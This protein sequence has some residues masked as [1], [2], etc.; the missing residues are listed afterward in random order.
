MALQSK[1]FRGDPKLEAAAVS[2]PAHI[3]QGARGEHVRKIQQALI[4]LDGADIKADGDYGPATAKAVLAY[5]T[6]R[7]II[8][9]AYQTQADDIVGKMTMA[10]LDDEMVKK[11]S[12]PTAPIQIVPLSFWRR[13]PPRNPALHFLI[14]GSHL[15]GAR[16]RGPAV[17]GAPSILPATVLEMSKNSSS[18]IEVL[19]GAGGTVEVF[20]DSI[21]QVSPPNFSGPIQHNTK[22]PVQTDRETFAVGSFDTLGDTPIFATAADGSGASIDV[23]VTGFLTPPV[24]H[25]LTPHAHK[26]SGKWA[27]VQGTPHAGNAPG[28]FGDFLAWNCPND[29][30]QQLVDT[31]IAFW[32]G[33]KPR[34][35][36]HLNWYL[37]DGK[38]SDFNEDDNIK[39]W[40][41]SDVGIKSRL[42]REIFPPGAKKQPAGHFTFKAGEHKIDDFQSSFGAIDRVD[43]EVNFAQD[44][45]RVWFQDRYEWHPVYPFYSFFSDDRPVRQDNCLHAALVELKTSGAADFW[46]KGKAEVPL[47]TITTP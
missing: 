3:M 39:A 37:T 29:T 4:T 21:V 47:A 32:F 42:K 8:N 20:N 46:M 27:L 34:A 15:M 14:A 12:L 18:F 40:L 19:N 13:R 35:L 6:Q 31:A 16:T 44:A 9:R 10:S 17:V 2:D 26:A 24:F 23:V 38:G 11:E 22:W 28:V 45:L 7:G 33:D 30:P 43:F 41:L 25:P 1:L 36:K 5:K